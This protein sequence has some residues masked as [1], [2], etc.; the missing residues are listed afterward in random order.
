MF[1]TKPLEGIW[2][3]SAK[4]VL[5]F[6]YCLV[7]IQYK[8][9]THHSYRSLR[10]C[11][12]ELTNSALP[13][14]YFQL[15]PGSCANIWREK[16][17]AQPALSFPSATQMYFGWGRCLHPT[18]CSLTCMG[19]HRCLEGFACSW[20][21]CWWGIKSDHAVFLYAARKICRTRKE[22]YQLALAL[23]F[24]GLVTQFFDTFMAAMPLVMVI[25]TESGTSGSKV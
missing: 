21:I 13:V 22:G 15:V 9:C 11:A 1:L 24:E 25:G 3:S 23:E 14:W 2:D 6:K 4:Q 16:A 18:L 7:F 5:V 12:T 8:I 17:G 19:M 10:K 20:G